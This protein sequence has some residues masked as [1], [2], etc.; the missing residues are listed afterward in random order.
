MT[1]CCTCCRAVTG[2]KWYG[3]NLTPKTLLG[4][5]GFSL[6]KKSLRSETHGYL[7]GNS[8][9]DRKGRESGDAPKETHQ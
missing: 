1:E 9:A 8:I 3:G 6:F 7:L 5:R 4:F 2:T